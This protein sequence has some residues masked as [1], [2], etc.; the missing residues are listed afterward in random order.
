MTGFGKMPK[1]DPK[2][3]KFRFTNYNFGTEG[4]RDLKFGLLA[5]PGDGL[6]G[7]RIKKIR[8]IVK[9]LPAV[10]PVVLMCVGSFKYSFTTI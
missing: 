2:M 7:P 8:V 4:P 3:A 1:N 10:S 5:S 6:H 9:Y